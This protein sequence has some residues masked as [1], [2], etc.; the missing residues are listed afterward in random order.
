MIITNIYKISFL[1]P[2]DNDEMNLFVDSVDLSEWRRD[3]L[4]GMI[5]FTKHDTYFGVEENIMPVDE[6]E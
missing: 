5:T 2:E 4:S 3:T 6:K 1:V